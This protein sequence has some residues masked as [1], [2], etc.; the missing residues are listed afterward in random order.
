MEVILLSVSSEFV[1]V[2]FRVFAETQTQKHWH[3]IL[4]PL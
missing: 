3:H 4:R 2:V 1:F